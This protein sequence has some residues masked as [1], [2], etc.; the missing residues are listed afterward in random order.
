MAMFPEW[1]VINLSTSG[2][3][4]RQALAKIGRLQA[5]E[6]DIVSFQYGMND[7]Y[8]LTDG[9]PN[10]G[11]EEFRANIEAL[12]GYVPGAS[13]LLVTNHSILEGDFQSYYFSRHPLDLYSESANAILEKY[14]GVIREI[15]REMGI[16]LLDMHTVSGGYD[17]EDF[18]RSKKNTPMPDGND[19]VHLHTLGN[20]VYAE[21]IGA[22]LR[23]L[24]AGK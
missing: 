4:S 17:L 18:L 1:E 20:R 21:R 13:V 23:S 22:C 11:L 8:L 15:A 10:V 2:E 16:M 19:G 24:A 12:I 6:P 7:H 14:N 3:S 5:L 9:A